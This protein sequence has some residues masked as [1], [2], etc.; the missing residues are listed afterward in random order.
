MPRS[1]PPRRRL[2]KPALILLLLLLALLAGYLVYLDRLILNTFEARLWSVSSQVYAA[3]LELYAGRPLSAEATERELRRLGYQSAARAD[4]PGLYQ[5]E[6]NIIRVI[7][8]PFRFADGFREAQALRLRFNAG[9]LSDLHDGN[10]QAVSLVR[11]DPA[12]IGSFFPGHG[13]DRLIIAPGEEPRLLKETLLLVED[14]NFYRHPGFDWRGIARAAWVNLRARRVVQGGSTLTQQL[15]KSYF[16]DNRRSLIRKLRELPMAILLERR[17]GKDELLNAYINEIYIGQDGSRAMHG[18]GL[19]SQ[20]YF[21]RPIDE[22]GP[23]EM[24][25]LVGVI[26]G[27]SYYNPFRHPQRAQARRDLILDL[28]L[29]QGLIDDASHQH[30][31]QQPMAL[32]RSTRQGG[33]YYPAFMDLVRNQLDDQYDAD[34]LASQGYR[35]YTTLNPSIQD[36]TEQVVEQT[37]G[38][39]ER[40]RE[41]PADSLQ[42][43][44]VIRH[45]RTG[46]VAALVGGRRPGFQGFNHALQGKRQ[47]G[48][49]I[50]PVIYLAALESGDFHLASMLN[51]REIRLPQPGQPDWVPSNFDEEI[52]GQVPLVRALGDSLNL[53]SVDL[54]LALGVPQ[55]ANRLGDLLDRPGPAPLPALLLG[56]VDY[57]PWDMAQLY[58][59][60][61]GDGFASPGHAVVSV[62]DT[63]G[64][65]S[66]RYPMRIEQKADPAA[67]TQLNTALQLVMQKG[68]GRRAVHGAGTAGKTGTSSNYRDSW[69]AGFDGEHLIVV[70]VGRQDGQPSGL[71]GSAGALQVWDALLG[72]LGSRPLPSTTPR[73]FERTIIDYKA[74]GRSR[75]GCGDAVSVLLPAGTQIAANSSCRPAS[76]LGERI[77]DWFD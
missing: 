57:S 31:T 64:T 43:A 1:R 12:L 2:L 76:R 53:A 16:L 58:A 48:S 7:L 36:A 74:G 34:A 69:F 52:H 10:G 38:R 46:E 44:V 29:E 71:T 72:E 25:L 11:L 22:L 41:M 75:D 65:L 5:R 67:V 61:A 66:A 24:A 37:L 62:A 54:G 59:I 68:T 15:V 9:R 14:R 18:F 17:F 30:A 39:I 63:R 47:V 3:P 26:R 40:E 56:A 13:E 45:V 60:F 50:K 4:R 35:V 28:M 42:A 70:W 33:R 21:D 49:L 8:R 73:Q 27:P 20:F 32:A 23:A 19:A 55:I 77:R 51:D 6:G